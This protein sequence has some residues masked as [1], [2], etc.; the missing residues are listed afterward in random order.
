MQTDVLKNQ[1][2]VNMRNPNENI[3][4]QEIGLQSKADRFLTPGTSE[5]SSRD[6]GRCGGR[7]SLTVRNRL[8]IRRLV[9]QSPYVVLGAIGGLVVVLF[10]KNQCKV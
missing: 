1:E 10:G 9:C 7:K 3:F 6:N 8:F 4:R 2:K 5:Y